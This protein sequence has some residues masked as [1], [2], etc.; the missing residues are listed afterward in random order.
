VLLKVRGT[1]CAAGDVKSM[2]E[3][4]ARWRRARCQS[5]RGN[6]SLAILP[7]AKTVVAQVTVP[8]AP[9]FLSRSPAICASAARSC[10]ITR[11]LQ[12]VCRRYGANIFHPAA[13]QCEGAR[14]YLISP[15]LTREA[16]ISVCAS[17]PAPGRGGRMT[18]LSLARGVGTVSVHQENINNAGPCR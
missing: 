12:V 15:V 17:R 3:G 2:A 16:C 9:G 1:F 5:A 4:R 6:G 7:D 11:L 18:A 8:P 14:M 13:R 10:K